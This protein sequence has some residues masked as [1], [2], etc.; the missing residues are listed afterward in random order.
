MTCGEAAE[1]M[2]VPRDRDREGTLR[3]AF[4]A[5]LFVIAFLCFQ[6]VSCVGSD[7]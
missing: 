7:W 1:V 5:G 2:R 6:C 4:V 3:M